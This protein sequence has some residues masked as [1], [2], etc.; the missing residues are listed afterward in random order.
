M[1]CLQAWLAG[2]GTSTFSSFTKA[3]PTPVY[4]DSAYRALRAARGVYG[5]E[6]RA[7]V[8][9]DTAVIREGDFYGYFRSL[10]IGPERSRDASCGGTDYRL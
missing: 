1:V 2:P 3:W 10:G 6:G 5:E 4:T 9:I 7:M 8:M